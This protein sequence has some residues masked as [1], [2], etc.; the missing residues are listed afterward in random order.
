MDLTKIRIGQGFDVH[1]LV[2]GRPLVLGGIEIPFEMGLEGHSDA[3]VLTHSVIDALLGAGGLGD[4]GQLFPD[5]DSKYKDISSILLLK[6]VR[7]LLEKKNL[8]VC[9]I[10]SVVMAQSPK[11]ASYI[12]DMVKCLSKTLRIDKALLS[13]KATTTERLGFVGRG[14]GIAAQAVVLLCRN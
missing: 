10:D 14:E 3:D 12:P 11:L 13:V 4:I 9:N 6:D 7:D 2:G 1:R 8:F 5:D